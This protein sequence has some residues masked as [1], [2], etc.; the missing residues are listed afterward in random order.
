MFRISRIVVDLLEYWFLLNKYV[1]LT[2]ICTAPLR[3][4]GDGHFQRIVR[5]EYVHVCVDDHS[6]IA[7]SKLY[8]DETA[9]SATDFL[10]AAVNYYHRLGVHV[11]RVLTDNRRCYRSRAF[12][13]RCTTLGLRHSYTRPFT[14]TTNGKAERFIQTALREWAYAHAYDTSAQRAQQLPRWL[15]RYNWHWPHTSLKAM[16]P[17]SR[18]GLNRNNL[19]RYHI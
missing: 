7:F 3:V 1:Y 5:V 8:P 15:H 13:A 11:R 9:S 16:T 18:L 14:P 4:R 10:I 12:N 2:E 19:L 6:R 17:I